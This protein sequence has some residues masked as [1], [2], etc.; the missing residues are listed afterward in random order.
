MASEPLIQLFHV[1]K[2]YDAETP[3]LS[4]VTLEISKGEFVFLTGPS[5]AGKSTLLKLLLCAEP[6]SSGQM[7]MF[8][9]NVARIRPSLTN[10]RSKASSPAARTAETIAAPPASSTVRGSLTG[11]LYAGLVQVC[12]CEPR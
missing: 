3:A 10:S 11:S 7:M 2:R 4:D 12:E 1:T 9:R 6:P 5:G 8:G